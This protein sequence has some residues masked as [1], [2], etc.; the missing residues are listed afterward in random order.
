MTIPLLYQT[1]LA[2]ALLHSETAVEAGCADA[3]VLRLHDLTAR[4]R[5]DDACCPLPLPTG[6]RDGYLYPWK[7]SDLAA[8]LSRHF[9]V[10]SFHHGSELCE[11]ARR[12][13]EAHASINVTTLGLELSGLPANLVG[14]FYRAFF[15]FSLCSTPQLVL[16][17]LY[18]GAAQFRN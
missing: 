15:G 17:I 16:V 11:A 9:N 13:K 7:A 3:H 10:Y 2:L 14:E 5:E 6:F 18:N 12:A 1:L 4:T 8:A